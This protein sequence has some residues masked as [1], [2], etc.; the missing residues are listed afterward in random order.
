MLAPRELFVRIDRIQIEQVFVNLLQNAIDAIREAG[1]RTREIEVRASRSD[2]G[3]AEIAVD[4]TGAGVSAAAAARLFEPFFTTKAARAW[5]W[6]WR[7]A[8]PSSRCTRGR[9]SVEPRQCRA[10]HHR[11]LAPDR[12]RRSA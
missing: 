10:G 3:R 6:A 12:S 7:S 9:L 1:E 4:D 11:A 2:D 8:A 5:A